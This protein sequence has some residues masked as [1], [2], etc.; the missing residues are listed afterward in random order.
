MTMADIIDNEEIDKDTVESKDLEQIFNKKYSLMCETAVSLKKSYLNKLSGVKSLQFAVGLSD[1]SIEVYQL[2][3]TSLLKVCRLSGHQKTLT[4]V[5]FSPKED[6]ILYSAGQDGLL[7][8]W[9]TRTSGSCVQEYKDEDEEFTKPYDCMDVSCNGRVMCAGSQVVQDDAYLVFWDQRNTSPLGGYWN[10]HTDDIS[11]V[12]FHKEKTEILA[13]GSLDGLTNVFNI[14]EQNE[15][16]ALLYSLNIEN[17]VEKIS[18]LDAT[19]VACV[20]QSNDLQVWDTDTGDLIRSYSRD[21]IAKSIKRS[22]GDDSY[23]VD[24]FM[25]ADNTPVLLAGS[26]AGNGNV[27]RSVGITEKKLQP[28]TNFE[29]NKQIVRCCWYEK[30]SD[31][32]VTTGESGVISVWHGAT[33]AAVN[34]G[35][36]SKLTSSL[37]KLHA[38]RHKPY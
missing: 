2:N 1:N 7:K 19:Q 26:C 21:K 37:K 15:D 11:Q 36:S 3:N 32:L 17:S 12:K 10:S 29:E 4:E 8:M 9:D 30:D 35:A 24:T 25:S 34:G 33:A 20:T 22:K 5:V 27:L 31:I 38:N 23:L 14:M 13:T 28:N 6:H 18:W 16:D